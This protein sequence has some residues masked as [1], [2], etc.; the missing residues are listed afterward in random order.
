MAH[1]PDQFEPPPV[2]VEPT[3]RWIRAEAGGRLVADSKRAQLHVAFGPPLVADS[4]APL[5]PGYF[6]PSDDVDTDLLSPTAQRDGRRWWDLDVD[7]LHVAE[8]AW[9]YAEPSGPTAALVDHLTYRWEA[10]DAWYEEA[11]QVFVHARDPTKRVDVLESSRHVQVRLGDRVLADSHRP[12]LLFETGLPTRYYLPPDD[13]DF[14]LMVASETVTACPY[15]GTA[16]YWSVEHAGEE[17]RDLAWSY[18]DPVDQQ[19]GLRGLIAFFDE[20][21]DMVVDGDLQDRPRTPWS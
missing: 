21:V 17:G 2:R 7:D 5:L 4:P 14:D 9:A 12:R 8:A 18:P 10:M 20:R 15:K 1:R 16:R 19:P 13:V 3:P 6:F 11:E